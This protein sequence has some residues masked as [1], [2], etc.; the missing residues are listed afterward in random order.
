MVVG[1]WGDC[2]AFLDRINRINRI[3]KVSKST[4]ALKSKD[5]LIIGFIRGANYK[6]KSKIEFSEFINLKDY[7]EPE[8]ESPQ[9]FYLTGAI[10]RNLNNNKEKFV[11][12]SRDPYNEYAWHRTNTYVEIPN[13]EN[14]DYCPFADIKK[15]EEHGQII[16]LFYNRVEKIG[17]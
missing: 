3:E 4:D 8:I 10:I 9:N 12:Y 1:R 11:S 13:K 7:I 15:E 5:H 17:K 2:K 14:N 16:M 6:N